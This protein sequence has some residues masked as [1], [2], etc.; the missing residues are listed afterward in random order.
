M[1]PTVNTYSVQNTAGNEVRTERL[2]EIIGFVTFDTTTAGVVQSFRINPAAMVNTRLS[3]MA[4]LY[5]EFKFSRMNLNVV[6]GTS[7]SVSGQFISGFDN[8]PDAQPHV[9]TGSGTPRFQ[10]LHAL[11]RGGHTGSHCGQQMAEG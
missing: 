10:A 11:A 2:R 1:I 5:Q 7:T 4:T 9:A 8:N 6:P 3:Q